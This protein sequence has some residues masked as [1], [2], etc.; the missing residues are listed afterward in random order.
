M[1][2]S[3]GVASFSGGFVIG[4]K[5][6]FVA[7]VGGLNSVPGVFAGGIILARFRA[8]W[9]AVFGPD[10]R[11]AAAFLCFTGLMIARPQG[12]FGGAART[13]PV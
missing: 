4:L 12:L 1:A 8:A 7:V 3:Y 10:C 5:T 6:L 11:D 2:L 13:E 9:S